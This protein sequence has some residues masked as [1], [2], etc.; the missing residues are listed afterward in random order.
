M[1]RINLL[2]VPRSKK[3]PQPYDIRLEVVVAVVVIVATVAGCMYYSSI[4]DDEIA[5]KKTEKQEK[6]KQ[7]AGLKE[8][9]K[10]V[11]NFEQ[12][13]KQLE[14]K[15]RIIDQLEQAR[16]GPVRVMDAVSKSL[17]PLRLWLVALNVKGRDVELDGRA[18][19][20]DE[21]VTFVKNLKDSDR[22]SAIKLT[23][24][25]SATEGKANVFQF[26]MILTVKG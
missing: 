7:L 22:F 3:G 10:E 25:R 11:E 24:S 19:T 13:K 21:V 15:N 4:L 20:N 9:I 18:F 1:I 12:K 26:K 5:A 6:E 16:G 2:P 23:E 8:K 14:D 17:D